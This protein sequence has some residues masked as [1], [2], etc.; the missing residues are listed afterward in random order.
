MIASLVD[1][2]SPE[3]TALLAQSLEKLQD[4]FRHEEV[5]VEGETNG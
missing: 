2:L 1:T 3:Q 5:A 4:F